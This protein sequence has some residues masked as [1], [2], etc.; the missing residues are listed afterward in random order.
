MSSRFPFSIFHSTH[1]INTEF[2]DGGPS[3]WS[4]PSFIPIFSTKCKCRRLPERKLQSDGM[5]CG[6]GESTFASQAHPLPHKCK[7]SNQYLLCA[8]SNAG[9]VCLCVCVKWAAVA[10]NKHT[11]THVRCYSL[12]DAEMRMTSSAKPQGKYGNSFVTSSSLYLLSVHTVLSI[13][14]GCVCVCCVSLF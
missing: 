9:N 1:T 4:K 11:H 12:L 5:H 14:S 13:V 7:R 3:D 6:V 8:S 2:I 10:L